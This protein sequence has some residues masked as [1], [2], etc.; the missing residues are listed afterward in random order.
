MIP[1]SLIKKMQY[2]TTIMIQSMEM[3]YIQAMK[4]YTLKIL[5]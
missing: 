2:I 1:V 3:R 4:L 5:R